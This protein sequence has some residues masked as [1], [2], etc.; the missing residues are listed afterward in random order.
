MNMDGYHIEY[1]PT[2][3]LIKHNS[4]E[5]MRLRGGRPKGYRPEG[6]NRLPPIDLATGLRLLHGNGCE[7]CP[8][9]LS[10]VLP[11]CRYDKGRE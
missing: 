3:A 6:C 11:R 1:I 2:Y 8:N 9:C 4:A 7:L 5:V 10:C